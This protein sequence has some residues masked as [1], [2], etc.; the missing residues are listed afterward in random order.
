MTRISAIVISLLLMIGLTAEAQ[1]VTSGSIKCVAFSPAPNVV[2][3]LMYFNP[4]ATGSQN[5]TRVRVFDQTGG[6][7][8][9][10]T[11][12]APGTAQVPGRGSFPISLSLAGD[13]GGVQ[14]IV[15]WQQGADAAAPIL[16][17]NLLADNGVDFTSAAQSN[18]P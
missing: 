6:A 17:L 11:S 12:P 13:S 9:A 1:A 14:I 8:I 4:N 2:P 10:D 7:P 18:C 15:N 3:V 5:I 16:R